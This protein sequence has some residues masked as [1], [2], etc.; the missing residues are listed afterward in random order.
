[1]SIQI[2]TNNSLISAKNKMAIVIVTFILFGCN[3][4]VDS[5]STAEDKQE[6]VSTEKKEDN[7]YFLDVES[8]LKKLP[9]PKLNEFPDNWKNNSY[10]QDISFNEW[11]SLYDETKEVNY[12]RHYIIIE[13]SCGTSCMSGMMIDVRNGNVYDLP[14]LSFWEGNGNYGI[15]FSPEYNLLIAHQEVFNE[16]T[17]EISVSTASWKWIESEK[18][19]ELVMPELVGPW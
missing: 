14:Q 18:R 7:E 5:S 4:S 16:I 12:A 17:N 11:K 19:F 9:F 1:M 13:L 6:G 10:F 15:D 8:S 2:K 3:S